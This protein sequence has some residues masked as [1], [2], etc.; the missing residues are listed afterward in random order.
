MEKDSCFQIQGLLFKQWLRVEKVDPYLS[1]WY[2]R[3]GDCKVQECIS[4]GDVEFHIKNDIHY[5][6]RTLKLTWYGIRKLLSI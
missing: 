6:T 3:A 5:N 4:K 1:K 2:L